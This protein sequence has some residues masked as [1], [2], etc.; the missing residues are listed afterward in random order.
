MHLVIDSSAM[1]R[2]ELRDFLKKSPENRAVLTDYAAMEAYS[3]DSLH[4]I[5]S[6]MAV[7]SDFPRQ[8]IVL[9]N[10]SKAAHLH[11]KAKGL[12]RRLIDQHQTKG[13]GEYVANLRKA[14]AGSPPLER[15]L[16]NMGK[17]ASDHL[18]DLQDRAAGFGEAVKDFAKLFTP[19][20][21]KVLRRGGDFTQAAFDKLVKF[22]MTIAAD[23]FAGPLAK[24]QLP[25]IQELPN[26]VPF[27]LG[28]A[29]TVMMMMWVEKGG[30]DAAPVARFRNDLVD[31]SFAAYATYF[32]GLMTFDNRLEEIYQATQ[33]FV[34]LSQR[35]MSDP[36]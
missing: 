33:V 29:G 21:I 18:T 36:K 11:G 13:F 28:L 32:D 25:P 10:T 30:Y 14:K 8:I 1:R 24:N 35:G 12:R 7:V 19:D 9:K 31:S 34:E 22:S 17:E 26:T 20:E 3:G 6:S 15:A 5:F 16:L 27:R 2:D 23:M 4:K